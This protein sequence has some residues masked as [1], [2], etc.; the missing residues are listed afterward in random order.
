MHIYDYVYMHIYEFHGYSNSCYGLPAYNPCMRGLN[1][2][3]HGWEVARN[4]FLICQGKNTSIML[5]FS[6]RFF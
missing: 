5:K 3:Y 2:D 1:F 4:N 6:V